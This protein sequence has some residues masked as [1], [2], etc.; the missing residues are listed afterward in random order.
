[1]K[2]IS[3][4]VSILLAFFMMVV[5]TVGAATSPSVVAK[6]K[7]P[8]AP[9]AAVVKK[10]VA[11][12]AP[13]KKVM[14]RKKIVPVKKPVKKVVAPKP[15]PPLSNKPCEVGGC[16]GTICGEPGSNKLISTCD[17]KPEYACYKQ[18]VCGRERLE[19][20]DRCVWKFNDAFNTCI[21]GLKQ[22]KKAAEAPASVS[23]V[24]VTPPPAPAPQ[25][26]ALKTIRATISGFAFN[27]PTLEVNKGDTVIWTQLDSAP[28]TV[29]SD[30]G[31]TLQSD[32][33]F[34]GQTYSHT[35]TE[36]GTFPYHCNPHPSMKGTVVVK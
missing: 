3:L 24:V 1:M 33:L 20:R 32:A 29:T 7:L 23:P 26:A 15:A 16:S 21:E 4:I 10:A 13:V 8:V 30:S 11:Q 31:T 2:K 14:P 22:I 12:K 18:A 35:F 5:S 9:K 19:G 27:P 36:T 28:H 34:S 25:A 6:K 17:F